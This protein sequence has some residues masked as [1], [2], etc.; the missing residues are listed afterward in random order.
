M[1]IG[2]WL[3]S[4]G[5]E[6]H[7]HAFRENAIDVD[8]LPELTD[9][10][11]KELG[12]PL[13]HRLKLLKAIAALDA[14]PERG[15]ALPA[16]G[17]RRQV[18]VL[19]AD[20]VGYTALASE[21]GAEAVHHLLGRFFERIDQVIEDHG[22]RIDKHIGDCAMAVFGAPRAHG[23]DAE[24][25]LRAALAIREQMAALSAELERDVQVRIGV[26]AGQVV[27]SDTGSASHREYTV[28]G[29]SVNLASRLTDI[30]EPGE[31]LVPDGLWRDLAERLEGTDA[32]VFTLKG[33]NAPVH[34][35]KL[36]GLRR[37]A[38]GSRVPLIGR[39][40]ELQQFQALLTGCMHSKCGQSVY[41]RGEAGIG[42]TRLVE[43]FQR[44]AQA[45]GYSC[46]SGLV[47]DFGAG[48]GRDAIAM[49]A[50]GLLG[51]EGLGDAATAQTAVS[52]AIDSGLVDSSD[53]AYLNDLLDLPQPTELR[54]FYDALDHA[55]RDQGRRATLSRLAERASRRHPRLL[56]VEDLHWAGPAILEYVADLAALVSDCPAILVM[57]SRIDGDPLDRD[58]RSRTGGVSL[59]TMDVGPLRREEAM[60]LA[61]SFF[62]AAD[63]FAARCVDRAAGNP[64][65]LEQLLRHAEHADGS[66]VPGSVQSLVQARIDR[67]EIAEKDALQAAA[68]LGQRFD[69][70]ALAH[71]VQ[72]PGYTPQRL[73]REL[74]VRPQG[75][76]WL[77]AH[78]LIR[79][80]VYDTLLTGWRRELHRRAADWYHTRDA[81]LRAEHLDRA[82]DPGAAS[83]YLAAAESQAREYRYE[84]ALQLAERGLA[85]ATDRGSQVIMNCLRGELLHDLGDM[86]AAATAFELARHDAELP[87]ER[88][89]A[90]VGL[91]SVKRMTDDLDGALADLDAAGAADAEGL[92]T[93]QARIHFLRGNLLFPRGDVEGCRAEHSR[94]LELAR[95]AGSPELEAQALGGLGDAEYMAG[96]LITADRHF[97]DCVA[98]A[99]LH[100]LGR[101]EVANRPMSAFTR[102]YAC[103]VASALQEAQAAIRAAQ[104]VGH[105]RA[106]I[107][108]HHAAY[109][110]RRE[111]G[112]LEAAMDD[113][114]Q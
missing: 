89:R 34:A 23:N 49:L 71:L 28:T 52:R 48:T 76:A 29:D 109:F 87:A 20:L 53:A 92:L 80:A 22:G 111:M 27:A 18:V 112:D 6:R 44:S 35:W 105:A 8:V 46:H 106:E 13:G 65:F 3:R 86:T 97:R 78:A 110:C 81:V 96:R 59:L 84:T 56:V 54:A 72:R 40:P 45:A 73:A 114:E 41:L 101:I 90:L 67:L 102:L 55:A 79:D 68:V 16:T 82:D 66:S 15:R 33:F 39:R 4:L 47:L 83:A 60:A 61:S 37:A 9:A 19:F 74:L 25:A 32:G 17:E 91:A 103:D 104:R 51:L 57:T 50:R 99:S 113:V 38:P 88:C 31:I 12:L 63:R 1:D 100:G 95:Q 2:I 108:A 7:A 43:E 36:S 24:R 94:S 77:F 30:G 42:K 26:A 11:L 10:A 75:D 62:D 58:W 64:L 69:V 70:E 85:L 5:L 21:I 107:I 14:V 93:E 98:L